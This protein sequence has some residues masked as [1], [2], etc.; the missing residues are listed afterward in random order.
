MRFPCP[1]CGPRDLREFSYAGNALQLARPAP[2]ADP[3]AWD[4]YVHNREN[5]AGRSRE[6]WYHEAGCGAWLVIERDTVT[7]AVYRVDLASE[8]RAALTAVSTASTASA[9]SEGPEGGA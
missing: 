4:D 6:L 1:H 7:H 8:A 5:P 9:A 3:A 2:D